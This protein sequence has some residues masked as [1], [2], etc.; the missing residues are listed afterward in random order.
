MF[1]RL[2]RATARRPDGWDSSKMGAGIV[3]ARA[4]LEA[5]F[6]LD[7]NPE[8]APQLASS[9]VRNHSS[10]QSFVREIVGEAGVP[11]GLEWR[12]Y[13]PE[14]AAALLNAR[15]NA[16][17]TGQRFATATQIARPALSSHLMHA[18]ANTAL[19]AALGGI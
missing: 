14:I 13:G 18:V 12:R 3:D 9:Q 17:A 6:D 5:D 2:V 16:I 19:L 4:L 10:I 1:R 8:S 15:L 11:I 7:R